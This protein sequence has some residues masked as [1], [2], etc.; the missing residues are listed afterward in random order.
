M[1]VNDCA[2]PEFFIK[3]CI[4]PLFGAVRGLQNRQKSVFFKIGSK[5]EIQSFSGDFG[6]H[7]LEKIPLRR[8]RGRPPKAFLRL[9]F[10][11]QLFPFPCWPGLNA[12]AQGTW[13]G[14]F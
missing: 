3:T 12:S 9:A 4:S 1:G 14:G 13:A 5:R 6:P 11:G 7:M 8:G 2:E 10:Q